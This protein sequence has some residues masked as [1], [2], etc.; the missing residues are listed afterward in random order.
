MSQL[1]EEEVVA[2]ASDEEE[3]QVV[4]VIVGDDVAVDVVDVVAVS[5]ILRQEQV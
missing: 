2:G 3:D 4:V 1:A 5:P